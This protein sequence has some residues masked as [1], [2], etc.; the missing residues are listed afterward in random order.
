VAIV[1]TAPSLSSNSDESS[2]L[3]KSY[4]SIRASDVQHKAFPGAFTPLAIALY[5]RTDGGKLTADDERNVFRI[6]TELGQTHI[7]QVRKVVPAPPSKDGRY[8]TTLVQMNR[9]PRAS[10]RRPTLPRC[11]ASMAM[12]FTPS[13]TALV[14]HAAWW[15]GHADRAGCAVPEAGD[16]T[17]LSDETQDRSEQDSSELC[18]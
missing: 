16:S 8:T 6:T 15:P 11:C 14:G 2:L 17:S 3:P 4:E 12:F 18:S 5:Q 13:L 7:D 1:A 9:R 10:R